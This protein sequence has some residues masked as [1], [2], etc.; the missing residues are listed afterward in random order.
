V[1][2]KGPLEIFVH[3]VYIVTQNEKASLSVEFSK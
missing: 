1:H 2:V 3:E